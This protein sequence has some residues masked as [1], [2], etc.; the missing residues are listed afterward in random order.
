M[1]VNVPLS[2]LPLEAELEEALKM[3][4][5]PITL[6]VAQNAP[7]VTEPPYTSGDMLAEHDTKCPY[8]DEA[9]TV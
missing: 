2:G 8:T 4:L 1:K 5:A 7:L 3:E 9:D 6:L